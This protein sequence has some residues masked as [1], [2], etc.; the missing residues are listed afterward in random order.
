MS[1]TSSNA[2]FAD[3]FDVITRPETISQ[4]GR[5]IPSQV[6]VPGI[7]GTIYATGD[8]SL[9]RVADFEHGRKT[10]TICTKHR[11]QMAAPGFQP[12]VVLYRGNQFVVTNVKDWSPY[13]AGYIEAECSSILALDAPPQ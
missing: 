2:E 7:Y 6:R 1:A 3:R 13:G 12:D 8:N 5:S 10:L 9:T 11:L 4:S